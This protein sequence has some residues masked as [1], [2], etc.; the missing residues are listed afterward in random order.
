MTRHHLIIFIQLPESI[1]MCLYIYVSVNNWQEA[2]T[3]SNN[4]SISM[5]IIKS[6][7]SQETRTYIRSYNTIPRT[8][9]YNRNIYNP[10]IDYIIY[11]D[12]LPKS[13][14]KLF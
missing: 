13:T 9:I 5:A 12:T 6:D 3:I 7:I 8:Y 1:Y 11:V 2:S 14:V 4:C 10:H